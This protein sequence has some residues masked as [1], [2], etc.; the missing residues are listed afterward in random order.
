MILAL[1]QAAA[2]PAATGPAAA[3][4]ARPLAS[5]PPARRS[6]RLARSGW[7]HGRLRLAGVRALPAGR[8]AATDSRSSTSCNVKIVAAHRQQAAQA[9][10]SES[11]G[12]VAVKPSKPPASRRLLS[13]L[14]ARA[15]TTVI[16]S[17]LV[18]Y[19]LA[20]S[21]W[22]SFQ[23]QA[24]SRMGSLANALPL[25]SSVSQ[26][27]LQLPQLPRW[28][29]GGAQAPEVQKLLGEEQRLA[30]GE[31]VVN[32]EALRGDNEDEVAAVTRDDAVPGILWE[33]RK[34]DVEEEQ[35]KRPTFTS[36]GFSYSAAGLLFPYHLGVTQYLIDA[37]MITE[38]TPLAGSSAGAIV[39]AVVASGVS[40]RAAV[41]ATKE[42]GKDCREF[43]TAFR[44]GAVLRKFL[45]SFLPDDAHLS[46]N[47]RIRVQEL[48]ADLLP[49]LT[50]HCNVQ[51]VFLFA[52]AVT[53]VFRAPRGILVDQFDD[54][55]DLINALL[56]SCYIPGFL[57]PAPMTWFRDRYCVDG[58]IS[59]FMPPT[60]TSETVRVCCFPASALGLTSIGISPDLRPENRATM[61]EL[62]NW[63]LE[64]AT[65]DILE[66]LYEDG[67]KDA[68]MWHEHRKQGV[69]SGT[70]QATSTLKGQVTPQL[71]A[72]E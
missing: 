41:E 36:P 34:K 28:R 67:Y 42:L 43:G 19:S 56:T 1:E 30:P 39:C 4:S 46:C 51:H 60:A 57:A 69:E 25:A 70:D 40:M 64:P 11:A 54:K 31:S 29:L 9:V 63:A 65:D 52:V 21:D 55:E 6:R 13:L 45:R 44:L 71:V 24:A 15:P 7:Q 14:P 66:I 35:R 10:K 20:M 17:L 18:N 3:R 5:A 72:A 48:T 47:G 22:W 27:R 61:R 53:Q 12:A 38:S 49:A 16:T 58:G 50:E 59:L 23:K 26:I 68:A 32:E 2:V 62:F 33:Q 37:G 8:V